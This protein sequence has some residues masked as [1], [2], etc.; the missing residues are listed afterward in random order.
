[1]RLKNKTAVISGAT[2]GI[3]EATSKLFSAEGANVVM[4]GRDEEKLNTLYNS[5]DDKSKLSTYVADSNNEDSIKDCINFAK[6]KYGSIDVVFANAG[7]E[8]EVKPLTEYTKDEFNN[9]LSVNV[10]GVWLYMKHALPI[11]QNQKNGSF[12]LELYFLLPHQYGTFY[13]ICSHLA[14]PQLCRG[15]FTAKI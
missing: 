8:G 14:I 5:F 12:I 13:F 4:V 10:I 3:G 2:G 15:T 1:M 7:T 11:M 6:D 9:V